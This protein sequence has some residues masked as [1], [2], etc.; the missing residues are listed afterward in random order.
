VF[1][2]NVDDLIAGYE[3][4]LALG[5][6]MGARSATAINYGSL[7][8]DIVERLV[9]FHAL[10]TRHGMEAYLEPISM[11]A[12]R[13]LEDG[14]DLIGAAGVNVRLVV[15]IIHL[16]RTGGSPRSLGAIAPER[17]GHIQVC[18]GPAIVAKDAIGH[19][20]IAN[21]LYPGEGEF[22]L[23]ELLRAAPSHASIGVETPSL[24]RQ[25]RGLSPLERAREAIGATRDLLKR[26]VVL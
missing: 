19:E 17:I 22:P 24:E 2:L 15:D 10:C 18:D 11:G 14:A 26:V 7:R 1:N 16:I 20:S 4:A 12:T 9:A 3:P 25:K 6:S 23:V 8:P 13:T 5:A 21:R